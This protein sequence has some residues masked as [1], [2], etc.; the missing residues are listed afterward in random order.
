MA[1]CLAGMSD[2]TLL[3]VVLI[4]I[5]AAIIISLHRQAISFALDEDYRRRMLENWRDRRK[6]R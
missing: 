3:V 5:I 4:F 2:F 1:I 6:K